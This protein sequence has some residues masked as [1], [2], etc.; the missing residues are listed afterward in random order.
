MAK[1][2]WRIGT[3]IAI[4]IILIIFLIIFY[5]S[6]SPSLSPAS[7]SFASG[8][9][10]TGGAAYCSDS[11]GGPNIYSKGTV[12]P[13]S[14]LGNPVTDYCVSSGNSSSNSSQNSNKVMEYVCYREGA[15]G[16]IMDCTNGCNNGACLKVTANKTNSS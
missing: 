1:K 3:I 8:G 9:S 13:K 12:I 4:V 11:D 6:P 2:S 7:G 15:Y 5:K 16:I 14:G 10:G